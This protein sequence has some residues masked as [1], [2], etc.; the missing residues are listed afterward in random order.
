MDGQIVAAWFY[1]DGYDPQALSQVF[2]SSPGASERDRAA[3]RRAR[4]A[5]PRADGAA[6]RHEFPFALADFGGYAYAWPRP[7]G[8]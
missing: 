4:P 5:A 6:A 1:A 2:A 8:R 3:A 7:R